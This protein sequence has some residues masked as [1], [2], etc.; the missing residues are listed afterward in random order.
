MCVPTPS[1]DCWTPV[2]AHGNTNSA[3]SHMAFGKEIYESHAARQRVV[4]GSSSNRYPHR[5]HQRAGTGR[6]NAIRS[7]KAGKDLLGSQ[8]RTVIEHGQPTCQA[9][10]AYSTRPEIPPARSNLESDHQLRAKS[11]RAKLRLL[12]PWS[13]AP[14][15]REY[16]NSRRCRNGRPG[17]RRRARRRASEGILRR[18]KESREPARNSQ[19]RLRHRVPPDQTTSSAKRPAPWSSGYGLQSE[20]AIRPPAP[21]RA[22]NHALTACAFRR[23]VNKRR[24]RVDEPIDTPPRRLTSSRSRLSPSR[25]RGK[26]PAHEEVIGGRGFGPIPKKS[27]SRSSCAS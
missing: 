11:R 10:P 25:L 3:E 19:G 21:P 9:L 20:H 22:G 12:K 6:V 7:K 4:L 2:L 18:E 14:A 5:I 8:A 16:G 17:R 27:E 15:R 13:P 1:Q 26:G 23:R 24:P